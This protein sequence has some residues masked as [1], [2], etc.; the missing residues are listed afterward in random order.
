MLT[1]RSFRNEDPPRLLELWKK[2]QQSQNGFFPLFSLS[3]N[4]FQTQILGLPMLDNRSIMLAFEDDTPLGYVHTTFAPSQDGYSFDYSTGQICFLCVDP[5]YSDVAGAAAALIQAG[6]HYLS[7]LGAQKIFGG[8]PPPSAPFYTAFYGGGEAVGILHSDKT[9]TNAFHGANYKIHKKTSWFH[10]DLRNYSPAI[11]LEPLAYYNELAIEIREISEAKTWWEGCIQAN[12]IWFDALAYLVQTGRPIARLRT[13]ISY[14]DTDNF[15]AMYGGTW[16]ASFIE[17]RVH[18]DFVTQKVQQFLL[19][20]VIRYLATQKQVVRIEAHA[21]EE[22]LLYE[23]LHNQSWQ[24]RDSGH[25]LV[26]EL[27]TRS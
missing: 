14:P 20:E 22:S 3:L 10:F 23:L 13:R 16:L 9:A 12:G 27:T 15:L 11:H 4:Q 5:E 26:K 25:I 1:I 18:P 17:M 6:E 8:S 19:E 24:E 7:K 21:S 2:T